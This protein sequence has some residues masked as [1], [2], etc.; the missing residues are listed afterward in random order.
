M[1]TVIDR[2]GE[3]GRGLSNLFPSRD[4]RAAG[5]GKCSSIPAHLSI[6]FPLS[7]VVSFLLPLQPPYLF[8]LVPWEYPEKLGY[9][10]SLYFCGTVLPTDGP[11]FLGQGAGSI[12]DWST[13][14]E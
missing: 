12:N 9:T 1:I 2:V 14:K 7:V 8:H 13:G 10:G 4:G 3:K 6:G 11:Q 5:D